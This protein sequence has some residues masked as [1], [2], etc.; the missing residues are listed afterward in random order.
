M[1]HVLDDVLKLGNLTKISAYCFESCLGGL[2]LKVRSCN[3][4]LEQ[5][6]RRISELDLDYREPIDFE[7]MNLINEPIFKNPIDNNHE[8]SEKIF[9][10]ILFGSNMLL[11]S[12]K[13]ADKWF[14]T[15]DGNIIEFHFSLKHNTEYLLYGSRLENLEKNFTQPISSKKNNIFLVKNE[16][17]MSKSARNTYNIQNVK[18]KMICFRNNG[19]LIF[20]PLLHTLK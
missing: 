12:R 5:I 13:F 9:S 7:Q 19:D 3:R 11:N 6:S 16:K 20:I 8:A 4:P 1:I 18:A 2:K 14:L 17:S 15:V 10:Q